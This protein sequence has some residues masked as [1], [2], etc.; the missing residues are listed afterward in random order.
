M[1]PDAFS[2]DS[3][4]AKGFTAIYR[5]FI[6]CLRSYGDC[7]EY[8][9]KIATW[10]REKFMNCWITV[11]EPMKCG[12]ETL[13]HGDFWLNNMMFKLNDAMEPEDTIML[14]FQG[15][16][17]ASPSLDF[18]YFIT[19]SVRDE[20]KVSCYDEFVKHYYSVLVESLEKLQYELHIP[21]LEEFYEDLLEKAGLGE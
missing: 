13:T 19:S 20:I 18:H 21:T 9:D 12:F 16:A 4:M 2:E 5:N 15:N 17:W 10:D 14:D 11:A 8:A 3:P 1:P 6:E 7:N